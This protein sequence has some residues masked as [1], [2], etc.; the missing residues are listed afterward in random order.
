M[1][2]KHL[3][4]VLFFVVTVGCTSQPFKPVVI[5]AASNAKFYG[6]HPS[7]MGAKES[8][9]VMIHGMCHK[10]KSWFLTT[11]QSF[12]KQLKM[13]ATWDRQNPNG[14]IFNSKAH[15]VQAYKMLFKK[16]EYK[17]NFYGIRFSEATQ[18]IKNTHLCQDVSRNT[19]PKP[20]V[21]SSDKLK[22]NRERAEIN[23]AVKNILLNDC[24]ADAVIY[25]G[26]T[27]R[28]IKTG[29]RLALGE[30]YDDQVKEQKKHKTLRPSPLSLI[31]SSLGSKVL[32]DALL[33]DNGVRENKGLKLMS[34]MT[35]VYLSA[36]QIPLLNLGNNQKRINKNLGIQSVSPLKGDFS[37][38]VNIINQIR[39]NKTK[40]FYSALYTEALNVI[41][42]TDPNDLLSYEI[43]KENYGGNN[44]VNVIV[45]NESTYD[46]KVI[47]SFE[48]PLPAHTGYLKN[49]DV[50]NLIACGHNNTYEKVCDAL[51]SN[52]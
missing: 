38:V 20:I 49:S 48:N 26:E 9:V 15:G 1:K 47:P 36:N 31:S 13:N 29:V 24:L 19:S 44:V 39:A 18:K 21:C 28:H 32:R 40:R 23:A 2:L 37:D 22:Y 8:S 4:M 41:S 11:G 51:I 6:I 30:I 27:G 35:H 10:D 17:I 14:E 3:F 52:E 45:S 25:L 5:D 34:N 12:A 33:P 7:S 42:F 16:D 43:T 46:F 50:I